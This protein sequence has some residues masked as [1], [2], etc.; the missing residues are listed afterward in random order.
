MLKI[1]IHSKYLVLFLVCLFSYSLGIGQTNRK[2]LENQRMEII[3]RIEDTDRELQNN[4][5]AK[6]SAEE[7]YRLLKS[8]IKDREKLLSSIQ[9]EMIDVDD[10]FSVQKKETNQLDQKQSSEEQR[11]MYIVNELYKRTR[12][13]N[14]WMYILDANS[15]NDSFKRWRYVKQYEGY[16]S[17]IQQKLNRLN[18]ELQA[19]QNELQL[20]TENKNQLL[21]EEEKQFQL[22]RN[23]MLQLEQVLKQLKGNTK[24]LRE[25]LQEQKRS[26]E[27][28]NQAI[29]TAILAA[30][31][32]EE[33]R[34]TIANTSTTSKPISSNTTNTSF[35]Q[36]KGRLAQPVSNG[37]IIRK[38]GKQRHEKF[39]DVMIQNNGIDISCAVNQ[40][41]KVVFE[42]TVAGISQIQGFGYVVIINHGGYYSVYSKLLNTTLSKNQQVTTGQSIGQAMTE[43]GKGI[44]HFEIW[45]GK[46]KLNPSHWI[47]K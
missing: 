35:E 12:S 30:L 29:E 18:Q 9:N 45:K 38:F 22:L 14:K 42:G 31:K 41:V 47:R 2:N 46:Q 36:N 33:V 32:G 10:Q 34:R 23:E 1:N 16:I 8:K 24:V 20:V 27:R 13:H 21:A 15:I 19:S 43:K 39:K 5:N 11:Y 26:R 28:L 40:D 17:E 6:K 37:K 7:N 3:Q 25:Q 44:V 4:I